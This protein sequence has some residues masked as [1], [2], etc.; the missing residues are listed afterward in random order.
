LFLDKDA[1]P[2]DVLTLES[3]V[4]NTPEA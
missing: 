1:Y 3:A 2:L 4:Q